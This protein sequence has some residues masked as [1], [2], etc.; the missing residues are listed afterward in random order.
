MQARKQE[1]QNALLHSRARPPFTAASLGL[2]AEPHVLATQQPEILVSDPA[3][4]G[5]QYMNTH[6]FSTWVSQKT[7]K[8]GG[9]ASPYSKC[10]RREPQGQVGKAAAS[11][12]LGGSYEDSGGRAEAEWDGAVLLF[13]VTS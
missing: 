13:L 2:S 9:T 11:H 5:L 6:I 1:N 7:W 3:P 8:S 12:A 4:S 10:R